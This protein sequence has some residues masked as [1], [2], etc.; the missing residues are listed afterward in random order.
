MF[1]VNSILTI[2]QT[3]NVHNNIEHSL[4]HAYT[5][6]TTDFIYYLQIHRVLNREPKKPELLPST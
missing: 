6:Y 3:V 1:S 2:L 4:I 5:V